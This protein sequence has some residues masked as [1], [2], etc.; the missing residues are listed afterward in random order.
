MRSRTSQ[1]DRRPRTWLSRAKE[2]PN[3][4]RT[5]SRSSAWSHGRMGPS[6]RH[7]NLLPDPQPVPVRVLDPELGHAVK[8]DLEVRDVQTVLPHLVVELGDVVRVEVEDGG[9]GDA[10]VEVDRLV[11]HQRTVAGGEPRPTPLI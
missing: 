11:Q 3:I 4:R 5:P 1:G 7:L 8:G 9:A 6:F 2:T 10:R